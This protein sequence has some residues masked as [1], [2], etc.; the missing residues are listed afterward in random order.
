MPLI[1]L[2][3]GI[4]LQAI[5]KRAALIYLPVVVIL[6]FAILLGIRIDG[7]GRV[8]RSEVREKARIE[9]AKGMIA[10][11][12]SEIGSDL[13]VIA[14]LPALRH[15]LDGGSPAQ[16]DELAGLFLVLAKERHRYDQV[17]Y[18]DASGQEV[19]R[20]NYDDG[21]PAIVPSEQLQDKSERYYFRNTI[22]LNQGEIY[23]SPLDLNVEHDRLEIPYK[24]MIR[25]GAPVFD[26]A[27]RKKGIILLNY[28]G[29]ELLRD[30]RK[31]MQGGGRNGMLL[32]RDGYWLS[33]SKP[34]DEWG[35]MLDKSER[36]FG[37]D[38]STE[39]RAISTGEEGTLLTAKG[40][41]V[42]AT[43][44]PL[45]SVQRSSSDS[46]LA[47]TPSKQDLIAHEYDWKIVSIVPHDV[48]SGAVFY[49][50]IGGRVLLVLAYLLL[51]LA[52]WI[53][54]VVILSREQTRIE[55]VKSNA[56]YDELTRRIPV[57]VYLFRFHADGS[58]GFEYVSP[59]F[60]QIL[61]LDADAV[62]RDAAI[63]FAAA[64]PDDKDSLARANQE[65]M[66][67]LTPFRWEGRFIVRSETRWIRIASDPAPQSGSED[68]SL[69]SGV[70]S[71]ITERKKLEH[72]LER[73]AHIDVLT[74]LNN[75]RH[76]TSW[77][78]MNWR[79]PNGMAS[80]SRH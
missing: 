56:R 59:V 50:Q 21:K 8:D 43:A 61:G 53:I 20:I 65:A 3:P 15:Y 38:F 1:R 71:D 9:L 76:F 60:C 45:L 28:L 4:P 6:S 24:P 73:Q 39:W 18:L 77:R 49:N 42:Y 46:D 34:E 63:A 36:T 54:G 30:F 16:R 40:Q 47:Y 66:L 25:F 52:A 69:W 19:I 23:V 33:S 72:E 51:A 57:G 58:M 29:S 22:G 48:L 37:R 55:L 12:F 64:H 80:R 79:A 67:S 14:S 31:A 74:G 32:N 70:V 62:L 5:F 35:F 26:S 41:F 11:D 44:Y 68:G 27:G 78:N 7:Q 75:R 10:Q 17:R 13:H 2:D